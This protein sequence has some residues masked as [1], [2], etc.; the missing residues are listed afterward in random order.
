MAAVQLVGPEEFAMVEG[1]ARARITQRDE[2]DWSGLA[3]ALLLQCPIWTENRRPLAQPADRVEPLR[4][5][6]NLPSLIFDNS[7]HLWH[8]L[9]AIE[10]SILSLFSNQ[11]TVI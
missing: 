4:S 3:A 5:S 2:R 6:G 11:R 9:H 10:I 8:L 1:Q 7:P